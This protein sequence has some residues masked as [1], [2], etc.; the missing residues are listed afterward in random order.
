[1]KY[2]IIGAGLSGCV[3]AQKLA[4]NADHKIFMIE[5]NRHIGG[6]C[7][8]YYDKNGVLVQKY[9]PHIFNTAQKEIWEYV[10]QFSR[11]HPYFHR[12]TGYVDGILVPI[13]FNLI[14]IQKLFPERMAQQMC[15]KLIDIYGY[16]QKV[17]ILKLREQS[18][19]QMQFL[20]DF[21]YEKVFL[22]YTM[23]QWGK[24]PEEIGPKAMARIP[25]FISSDDRYFQNPYQ[26]M[27]KYG[28]TQMFM[29]MTAAKNI[30]LILGMD[31]KDIVTFD[32][33][34][35]KILVNGTVFEGKVIFTACLDELFSFCCGSLPYRS[36]KFQ[37]ETHDMESFQANA[38]INY[39]NNYEYTRITEFKKL[40]GQKHPKTVI[41]KEV[42]CPYVKN[43]GL[44]PLY[45]V[46]VEQNETLYQSYLNLARQFPQLTLAGRLADY[47]YYTMSE[48][49]A[50]ALQIVREM[51]A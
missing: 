33:N 34:E 21:I 32:Q 19:T 7:Y 15:Q 27:P 3:I 36:L 46:P 20:A 14:S 11:Y 47:K 25:V 30:S 31:Y 2:L 23:K 8:D 44:E 13:P 6:A 43:T 22:H 1:M 39:P 26:G 9:G 41:L 18:D 40:T 42:P 5:K 35:K 49:I 17:P 24:R 45:P 28:Y 16:N 37:L 12:V 48:T 4:E 29:Q 51:E 38:T 50:N 10:N